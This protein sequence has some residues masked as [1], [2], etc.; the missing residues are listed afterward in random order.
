MRFL[1]SLIFAIFVFPSVLLAGNYQFHSDFYDMAQEYNASGHTS[2]WY[3]SLIIINQYGDYTLS[4]GPLY[5]S[6]HPEWGVNS[7]GSSYG[8]RF[9]GGQFL[10]YVNTSYLMSWDIT[11]FNNGSYFLYL[12]RGAISAVNPRNLV[13]AGFDGY[14][15]DHA[16][17]I[18]GAGILNS[19]ADECSKVSYGWLGSKQVFYAGWGIC[20]NGNYPD[21][22]PPPDTTPPVVTITNPLAGVTLNG[23]GFITASATDDVGVTRMEL[24]FDNQLLTQSSSGAISV[25]KD[26]S[27]LPNGTHTITAK[28]Y[29]A[30][31]NA[32]IMSIDVIVGNTPPSIA[33]SDHDGVP[34]NMDRCPNTPIGAH[35]A[36]DGCTDSDRD[37]VPDDKDKCPNTPLGTVVDALGCPVT[38]NTN[39]VSSPDYGTGTS[40]TGGVGG[41]GGIGGTGATSQGGTEVTLKGDR[42]YENGIDNIPVADDVPDKGQD[43]TKDLTWLDRIISLATSHPIVAMIKNS[44]IIASGEVCSLSSTVY[45]R[46]VT[47]SFCELSQYLDMMGY[48]VFVC[49]TIYSFMIIFRKD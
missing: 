2:D 13:N 8:G 1:W 22:N 45:G 40:Y 19:G 48:F 39:Q 9:S 42:S 11:S 34:D 20:M 26:V 10:Q 16:V 46:T 31:G 41:T 47:F 5:S 33:D 14:F 32:G 3:L 17:M 30:A 23:A 35:V 43:K 25:N 49:G 12:F 24:Y 27:G 29:D 38:G 6:S 21:P 44:R 4:V 7:S 37:G 28:A 36:S 18:L 15:P